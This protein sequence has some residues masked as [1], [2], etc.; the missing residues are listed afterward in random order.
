MTATVMPEETL[1]N[2]DPKFV[3]PLVAWLA[4]EQCTENGSL[5]EVAGGFIGKLRWQRTHGA[6]FDLPF[7]PEAVRD[8][9]EEVTKFDDKVVY[10]TSSAEAIMRVN[11]NL[12][13]MAAKKNTSGNNQSSSNLKTEEIM[14]MF[15]VFLARGEGKNVVSKVKHTF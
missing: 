2:L 6:L 14:G 15:R 3:V 5:F 13:R 11:E 8:K 7:T 1:K 4:H 12:E 10:P 9:W